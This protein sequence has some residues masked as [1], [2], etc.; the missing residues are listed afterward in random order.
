MKQL[1]ADSVTATGLVNNSGPLR[2]LS[3]NFAG[4]EAIKPI[5]IVLRNMHVSA[6][7][8]LWFL[9]SMYAHILPDKVKLTFWI[10]THHNTREKGFEN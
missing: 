8:F 7:G 4:I 2:V 5:V 6:H 1:R 9:N 10:K 3:T